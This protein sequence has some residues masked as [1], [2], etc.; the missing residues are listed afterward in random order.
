M[1]EF[2]NP[3]MGRRT[4]HRYV[5]RSAILRALTESLPLLRGRLLDFGCGRMPYRE[6]ILAGSK[7]H[8]YVGL[9]LS[10]AIVYQP[11]VRPDVVWDGHNIPFPESFFDCAIATEVLEHCPDPVLTLREIHRVLKRDAVFFFT[12]PFLWNL[13]EVPR[14]EY[15]Y[16]PFALRRHLEQA[17]FGGIVI[18]PTGGW[19]SALAQMLGLWVHGAPMNRWVRVALTVCFMPL[20][21]LLVRKDSGVHTDFDRQPMISGLYGTARKAG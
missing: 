11:G 16:T 4:I 20:I 19:H 7:V 18:K 6:Y 15:R 13:H 8:E 17:G 1:D 2:I 10:D 9:D 21:R 5:I 14:D 12:T 3:G